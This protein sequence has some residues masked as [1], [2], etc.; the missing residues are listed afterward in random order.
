MRQ[1]LC[2][3]LFIACS[4][5][6]FG[7]GG[8]MNEPLE[9]N[10]INS[11]VEL[12]V[13]RYRWNVDG[14]LAFTT[15]AFYYLGEA[16]VPGPTL[17]MKAGTSCTVTIRND[18]DTDS[19]VSDCDYHANY[20]HCADTTN[21]HVHGLYID[22]NVDDASIAILPGKSHT[23][24]YQIRED[25]VMGMFWYH[26]HYHGSSTLQVS[27]GLAGAIKMLPADSYELPSDI[28]ALYED[29]QLLLL[30]HV[31]FNGS[32]YDIYGLDT[33]EPFGF[34][35]YPGVSELFEFETITP[36]Q[37]YFTD[38]RDFYLINGLFEPVVTIYAGSVSLLRFVHVATTR[39][40]EIEIDDDNGECEMLLIARD[41]VFQ[42]VP[43]LPI[44]AAILV[45]GSRADV[46][47][48]CSAAGD[49]NVRAYPNPSRDNDISTQNRHEQETLFTL[50]VVADPEGT[51]NVKFPTSQA[52]L[53]SHLDDLQG[54]APFRSGKTEGLWGFPGGSVVF[55]SDG[56][57][58]LISGREFLGYDVD[59]DSKYI[60][61]YCLNGVYDIRVKGILRPGW[62]GPNA[63]SH[64]PYHQHVYRFQI[65]ND[66]FAD[67]RSL[68]GE[69]QRVGEWRD[70]MLAVNTLGTGI[71][72]RPVAFTG[73]M[74]MH[75]HI[76]QHEDYG[77]MQLFRITDD[78]DVCEAIRK[79]NGWPQ[80]LLSGGKSF[81]ATT[82]DAQKPS[83]SSSISAGQIV[84]IV[85]VCLVLSAILIGGVF[86]YTRYRRK[87][88]G[89][90][91]LEERHISIY[92]TTRTRPD[93]L[94]LR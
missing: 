85:M 71:R 43:Y 80:E 15:R 2:F 30:N 31:N 41:G 63:T 70:T 12:V 37:E 93:E 33:D 90:F 44:S 29:D 45:Q 68:G 53:P 82:F 7:S 23:Y 8:M 14:Q 5:Q 19:P 76:F 89:H 27:G 81:Q 38:E 51:H 13:A 40:M 74:M 18:L 47:V 83:S 86:W 88:A 42:Y 75:C 28:Q 24:R 61:Q 52:N 69:I 66:N 17:V 10:C 35:D 87:R 77:S 57:I 32:D 64:H 62:N 50:H 54:F 11:E 56:W 60:E 4:L 9:V 73:D 55:H 20:M 39:I 26:A 59:E 3:F 16:M 58:Q 21:I 22:P 79:Q 36:S 91:R 67:D 49:Y 65:I 48:R 94:E 25:H 78:A 84:L 6:V 92:E 1:L 46:A 34:Y 72:F